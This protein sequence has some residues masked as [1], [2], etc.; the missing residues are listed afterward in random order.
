MYLASFKGGSNQRTTLQQ[1][2]RLLKGTIKLLPFNYSY[3]SE[4]PII[5]RRGLK[6]RI[7]SLNTDFKVVLQDYSDV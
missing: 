3:N 5:K 2:G 6:F 4:P 1:Q 7:A